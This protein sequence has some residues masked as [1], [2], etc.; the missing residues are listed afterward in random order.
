[1]IHLPLDFHPQAAE[2]LEAAFDWYAERS[3]AAAV[4]FVDEVDDALQKIAAEP[5]RWPQHT[6][7]TRR[8]LLRRFPFL[9]IYRVV[10]KRV[11]I[12]AIAHARRRPGY[13]RSRAES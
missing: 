11:Q 7:G 3:R 1:M 10:D 12:I 9:V 4:A 8:Y 6:H 13:W 2:E 5:D